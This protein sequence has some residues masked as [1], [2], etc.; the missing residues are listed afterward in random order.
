MEGPHPVIMYF[1]TLL[2][3]SVLNE[4]ESVELCGM[5]LSQGRKVA[6][7]EDWVNKSKLT[8]TENLGNLIRTYD[9]NL[10]KQV[11]IKAKSS[12]AVEIE[13]QE[14]NIQAAQSL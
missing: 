11:Y 12:K 5:V 1:H 8:F 4:I 10:A 6:M 14:G 13:M 9:T 2:E 3:K 7:V